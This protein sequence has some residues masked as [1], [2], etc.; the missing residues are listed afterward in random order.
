[1]AYTELPT[2][3]PTSASVVPTY[4]AAAVAGNKFYN[5]GRTMLIV[6]NGS[7]AP[8]TVTIT[9]PNSA[10]GNTIADKTFTVAATTGEKW[11]KGDPQFYNQPD[12]AT[13][14]GEV[15]VDYSAVTTVTVA[16]VRL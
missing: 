15:Y 12:G 11:W 8:I 2:Q 16:A 7:G 3:S 4:T 5:D 14:A 6:K 9:T 10:D 1:M 13:D